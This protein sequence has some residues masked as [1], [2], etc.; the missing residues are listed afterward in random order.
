[1][2]VFF[3]HYLN[4][5]D[6]IK[7]DSKPS[8]NKRSQYNPKLTSKVYASTPGVAKKPTNP[9]SG[10]YLGKSGSMNNIAQ[11]RPVLKTSQSTRYSASKRYN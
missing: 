8:P 9:T 7:F 3:E 11:L 10:L 6:K 1:M 4:E 2:Q 5:K